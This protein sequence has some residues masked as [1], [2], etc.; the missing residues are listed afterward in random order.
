MLLYCLD[1]LAGF[2]DSSRE[3]AQHIQFM[4]SA[5]FLSA[6]NTGCSFTFLGFPSE[7]SHVHNHP[8]VDNVTGLIMLSS[9]QTLHTL[10]CIPST[11][12]LW[13]QLYQP[14]LDL[15]ITW[16]WAPRCLVTAC[17]GCKPGP[18]EQ[19]FTCHQRTTWSVNNNIIWIPC[20]CFRAGALWFSALCSALLSWLT[21]APAFVLLLKVKMSTL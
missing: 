10:V 20:G 2:S 5:D 11:C 17:W 12:S 16:L 4:F 14:V 1:V 15:N 21:G 8:T 13:F 6:Y 3:C 19:T 9:A 18:R 7:R